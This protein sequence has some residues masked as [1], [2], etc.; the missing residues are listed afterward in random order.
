[1]IIWPYTI[2]I[3]LMFEVF[4][5]ENLFQQHRQIISNTWH[6]EGLPISRYKSCSGKRSK[7]P[8]LLCNNILVI[9]D[10]T[11]C[12]ALEK[13]FTAESFKSGGERK[14][15][16]TRTRLDGKLLSPRFFPFEARVGCD[17]TIYF[18]FFFDLY[19]LFSGA[20]AGRGRGDASLKSYLN[21]NLLSR[22]FAVFVVQ[23]VT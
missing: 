16:I 7:L 11:V 22:S 4:L 8:A 12:A 10:R 14:K 5:G 9:N 3:T 19:F 13:L 18:T 21:S 23:F 1:M 17:R 6:C 20:N 15:L 2:A